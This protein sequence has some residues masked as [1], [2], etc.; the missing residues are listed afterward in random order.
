MYSKPC[1]FYAYDGAEPGDY[2]APGDYYYNIELAAEVTANFPPTYHWYGRNDK[3]LGL[4][5]QPLQSPALDRALER[6]GVMHQ[7]VVYDNA[8]HGVGVGTGT[9]AE[10]WLYDAADFWEEA[11]AAQEE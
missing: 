10:G 1:F 7:M 4:I 8:P 6:N 2:L 9:D 3:T 11:V 5:F